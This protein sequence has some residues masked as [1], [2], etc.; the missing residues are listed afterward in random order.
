MTGLAIM[1]IE[2]GKDVFCNKFGMALG[3]QIRPCELR[4]WFGSV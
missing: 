2:Q 3:F 1:E 4:L